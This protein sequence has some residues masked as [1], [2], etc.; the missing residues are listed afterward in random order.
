MKQRE[1]LGAESFLYTFMRIAACEKIQQ[2]GFDETTLDGHEV[3]NQWAMLV[4]VPAG[5]GAGERG[6]TVV[7]LECAG[8]LP[9]SE[10]HSVVNHVEEVWARGKAAVDALRNCLSVDVRD[11]LCPLRN[12]GVSPY[13]LYGVMHDTCNCANLVNPNPKPYPYP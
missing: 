11:V 7:T 3:L 1:A 4:D 5:D 2:W 9:C 10:A 13:K 8:V 6:C 12:G